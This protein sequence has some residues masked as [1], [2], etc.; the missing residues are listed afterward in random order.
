MSSAM[1][2]SDLS[3]GAL[4]ALLAAALFGASAPLGKGLLE[5]TS[6]VGAR[7][8]ALPRRG[9]GAHA[10]S[11]GLAQGPRGRLARQRRALARRDRPGGRG[12]R[13]AADADGPSPHLRGDWLTAREP[14][15]AFYDAPGRPGVSRAP[16][17]RR[18]GGQPPHRRSRRPPWRGVD[19]RCD[20][21][22]GGGRGGGSCSS[23]SAARGAKGR[24]RLVAAIPGFDIL[25][26]RWVEAGRNVGFMTAKALHLLDL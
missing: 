3:K 12:A 21:C 17:R 1:P 22:G 9:T 23:T 25:Q 26:K 15:D 10:R 14:G 16:R 6:P 20:G 11:L 4:W 8:V 5:H 2:R 18:A 19:R 7:G 24:D 13:S